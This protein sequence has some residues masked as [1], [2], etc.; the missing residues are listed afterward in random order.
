MGFFGILK[1]TAIFAAGLIMAA[2]MAVI[3]LTLILAVS[4]EVINHDKY[5]K[6]LGIQIPTRDAD[7]FADTHGG[8]VGASLTA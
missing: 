1:K 2:V 7:V 6:A 4:A 5:A 8:F 3:V